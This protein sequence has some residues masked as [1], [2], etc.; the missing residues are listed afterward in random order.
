M[1][2]ELSPRQ[3]IRE[4]RRVTWIGFWCN[5][6]LGAA[7]VAAGVLASSSALA[8][9]GI[10]SFSDFVSDAIVLAMA[11]ISRKNP[12]R[13]HL[14]GHGKYETLATILLAAVLFAVAVRIVA[15]G[16]RQLVVLADGGEIAR[17]GAWALAICVVSIVGKEWLYRYT[18]RVGLRIRSEMVVANACTT[19][20]TRGRPSPPSRVSRGRCFSDLRDGFAIRCPP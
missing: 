10:H 18:R 1:T 19:A 6:A 17:P 11:G 4:A 13:R 14:Y 3:C 5:A 16:V 12:D 20:A 8:A 7:K 2:K 9:D 15:H